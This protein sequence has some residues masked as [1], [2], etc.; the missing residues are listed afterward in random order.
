M[1]N[2]AF[3]AGFESANINVGRPAESQFEHFLKSIGS[4]FED[5]SKDWKFFKKGIDYIV[6]HANGSVRNVDVKG[7][8]YRTGNMVIEAMSNESTK[9]KG[10]FQTSEA[11]VLAYV[12]VNGLPGSVDNVFFISLPKLRD[13]FALNKQNCRHIN[14]AAAETGARGEKKTNEIYLVHWQQLLDS[15][16]VTSTTS[17]PLLNTGR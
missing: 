3:V 15:G 1:T 8:T 14:G 16:A 11:D 9:R 13:W 5:V 7:D 10:W 4:T 6:T 17:F 2:A 12:W